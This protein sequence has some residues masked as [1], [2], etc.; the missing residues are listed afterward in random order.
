MSEQRDEAISLIDARFRPILQRFERLVREHAEALD[1]AAREAA[2]GGVASEIAPGAEPGASTLE[3]HAEATGDHVRAA[4]IDVTTK[5]GKTT[6]FALGS[7]RVSIGGSHDDQIVV[8]G[9]PAGAGAIVL[10][11]GRVQY[12]DGTTKQR[13]PLRE[14]SQIKVADIVIVVRVAR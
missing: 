1:D 6:R 14:G 3:P 11:N 4:F 8:P 9:L 2:S 5:A 10:E 13:T 12:V 7:K